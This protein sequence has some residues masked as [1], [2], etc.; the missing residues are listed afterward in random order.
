MSW[1][2]QMVIILRDMIFDTDPSAY[3]YTSGRLEQVLV[4]AAYWVYTNLDFAQTY[5][6]DVENVAISPDPTEDPVDYDFVT[7]VC[8][9]ATCLVLGSEM[10]TNAMRA[11]RVTDGPSVID[12]TAVSQNM[13]PLYDQAMKNFDQ[14]KLAYQV[15]ENNVGKSVLSPYGTDMIIPYQGNYYYGAR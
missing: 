2:S 4:N 11:V 12:M 10:R 3:T 6:I 13:K 5:N 7:L 9:R 1:N 8:L 15:G 14:A